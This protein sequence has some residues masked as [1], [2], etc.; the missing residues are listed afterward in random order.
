VAVYANV[1]PNLT[2]CKTQAPSRED[3][4]GILKKLDRLT[5]IVDEELFDDPVA[6]DQLDYSKF[7][8]VFLSFPV[9]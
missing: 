5:Q 7:L 4:R 8:S 2:T 9:L 6:N 3:K 1:G